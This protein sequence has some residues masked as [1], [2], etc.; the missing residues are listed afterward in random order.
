MCELKIFVYGGGDSSVGIPNVDSEIII[1][2][3]FL[4]K[5]D[6][7]AIDF[8]KKSLAEFYDVPLS[9]INTE[10]EYLEES[11]G[12]Y[13][14]SIDYFKEEKPKGYKKEIKGLKEKKA[15]AEARIK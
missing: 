15:E 5:H 10:L 1:K 4:D 8:L 6:K 3:N 2:D 7:E 9:A 12:E 13:D 11:L 14:Y